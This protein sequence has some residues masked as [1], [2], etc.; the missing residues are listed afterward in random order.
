EISVRGHRKYFNTAIGDYTYY[1]SFYLFG[2]ED[3]RWWQGGAVFEY[4]LPNEVAKQ[5]I[6]ILTKHLMD[7]FKDLGFVLVAG[8]V[9][10]TYVKIVY[11]FDGVL[12]YEGL[13]FVDGNGT[14]VVEWSE[15]KPLT[16]TISSVAIINASTVKYL[17]RADWEFIKI[18]GGT[19]IL[20]PKLTVEAPIEAYE[21]LVVP[22]EGVVVVDSSYNYYHNASKT[23]YLGGGPELY[24]VS[25]GETVYGSVVNGYELG[26]SATFYDREPILKIVY[27]SEGR[28]VYEI[29]WFWS[30]EI[31]V[32]LQ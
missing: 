16:V 31:L 6:D 27:D 18:N 26:D 17:G 21:F 24:K 20:Y 32:N 28:H 5:K 7:L 2:G 29:D 19:A 3:I 8:I 9:K 15:D 25:I 14:V 12:L 1:Q 11:W 30:T 23:V 10:P 22:R 4:Y 13:Y